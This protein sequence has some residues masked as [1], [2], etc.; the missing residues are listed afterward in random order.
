MLEMSKAQMSLGVSFEEKAREASVPFDA[1]MLFAETLTQIW[2]K[3]QTIALKKMAA[4]ESH[5]EMTSEM[6]FV[7][8]RVKRDWTKRST[9]GGPQRGAVKG[10][11]ARGGDDGNNGEHQMNE[12]N[13]GSLSVLG[14]VTL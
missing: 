3:S 14:A 9:E 6:K 11:G 4:L 2:A 7:R 1:E 8:H 10:L 5:L 13:K 12:G